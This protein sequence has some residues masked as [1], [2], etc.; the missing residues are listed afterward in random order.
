LIDHQVC[1]TAPFDRIHAD[2]FRLTSLLV[3]IVTVNVLPPGGLNTGVFLAVNRLAR[4]TG[5]AH[6]FMHTW[7]LWLGLA[8][9][10]AALIAAYLA[11]RL[12]AN[13]PRTAAACAIALVASMTA[14]LC[15][16]PISHLVG[17]FRPFVTHPR[18]LVLVSRAGDFSFPSDHSVV[19]GAI[20]GG[21]FFVSFRWGVVAAGLGLF[22]GFARVYVG[23]HYPIDVLAGLLL[24]A[25]IAVGL[26]TALLRP[27]SR[28]A[29]W[30][31]TTP[32]GRVVRP[33]E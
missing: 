2:R 1:L 31:G 29:E 28:L 12:S 11:G 24:G 9:S 3:P 17:E 20:A 14:L 18:A 10:L 16:I 13:P 27:M 21:L 25:L 6:G 4:R 23:V 15:N 26:E 7:A 5:W 30:T 33:K 22:L 32:F 8:V 19:A